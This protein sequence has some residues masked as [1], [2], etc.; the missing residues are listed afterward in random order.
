MYNIYIIYIDI[1]RFATFFGLGDR[2]VLTAAGPGGGASAGASDRLHA[3]GLAAAADEGGR[4][5]PWKMVV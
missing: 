5:Q 4:S 3:M 1:I 2:E